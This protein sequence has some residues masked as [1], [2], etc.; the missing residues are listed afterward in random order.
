[1]IY[2]VDTSVAIKW[3][4]LEAGTEQAEWLLEPERD[5]AASDLLIAEIGNVLW[6][7]QRN[8]DIDAKQVDMAIDRLPGFFQLLSPAS[9]L[10]QGALAIAREI[11]HSVY[12]CM[13]LAQAAAL[14]DAC[15]VTADERF[16]ARASASRHGGLIQPL[17]S[18]SAA[19]GQ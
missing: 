16:V 11:G 5:L 6:R 18:L 9:G 4:V 2:V 7:K 1:M 12:D 14:T 13:F 10:I 19:G 17:T 8:G 15:L 3:F